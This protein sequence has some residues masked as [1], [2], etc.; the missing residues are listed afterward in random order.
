M[1]L[2]LELSRSAVNDQ[3]ERLSDLRSRAGTLLAAAS[4]AG[5]FS[6]LTHG[7]LD[8][9]AA[10]AL[11]AYVASVGACIYV[12]MPHRLST[13]FRG[14]VLLRASR[15]AGATDEEAYESAVNWLERIRSQNATKLDDLTRWYAAA[16]I[17]LGVEVSLWIVALAA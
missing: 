15:E 10:L 6:G 5:S 3:A 17:A 8:T 9:V 7:T 4:I 14:S 2:A 13:E 12:L 1:R 11:I 16:A